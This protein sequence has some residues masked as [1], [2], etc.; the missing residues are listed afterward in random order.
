M[1]E[2]ASKIALI[3]VAYLMFALRFIVTVL[4][5]KN[6]LC[7]QSTHDATSEQCST[8]KIQ[9]ENNGQLKVLLLQREM[10]DKYLIVSPLHA[11][12]VSRINFPS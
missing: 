2:N 4:S 1:Y 11:L 12:P 3:K 9:R 5:A 8:A 10:D 7:V 6:D